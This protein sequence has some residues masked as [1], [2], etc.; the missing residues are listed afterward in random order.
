MDDVSTKMSAPDEL[1]GTMVTVGDD[2]RSYKVPSSGCIAAHRDDVRD[3]VNL[4]FWP[5]R[6]S[7]EPGSGGGGSG[8]DY[9]PGDLTV[10]FDN[11][12]L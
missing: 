10:G 7:D 9:D 4:G 5:W 11:A 12:L 1:I 6:P 3:L 8:E 2:G